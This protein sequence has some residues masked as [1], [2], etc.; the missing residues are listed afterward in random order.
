MDWSHIVMPIA[1]VPIF[2]PG[3]II[4]GLGVGMIG[5]FFGMGG[6]WMVTPGLNILGFPM[7]FAIGTDITQM[8][9]PSLISTLR[10]SK[11]GNV[12]YRLGAIMVGG[13]VTGFECGAQ[14]IMWLERIGKVDLYVR[15]GYLVLLTLIAWLVFADLAKKRRK[16]REAIASGRPVDALA[17]GI[18]WHKTLHKI[19]IP[20]VI[21]FKKAGIRCSAWLPI[22]VSFLTG[23]LAGVLGIGGGLIRMPALIYLVGCPTHVAVGTD[24]FEVAIS[25]LYGAGSYSY[26]GR[27]ELLAAVIMLLGA[28]VGA[29]IGAVATKYVKGYGIRLFFGIA[30]VGCA[31]SIIL[32]LIGA[33][34]PSINPVLNTIATI[35]ILGLV[36]GL[37][38]YILYRFITGVREELAMKKRMAAHAGV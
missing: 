38:S 12:D 24:L 11:F 17:T 33:A 35:L 36:G 4:L 15:S 5:G 25:G 28:A 34:Y 27:T 21:Y 2:W 13:T 16:E 29:Q 26:K 10:H 23:L 8:A 18:E 20:P 6:G 32:K 19:K 30:V 1:G 14:L 31:L 9:G 7:A 37:S 3:L 22:S